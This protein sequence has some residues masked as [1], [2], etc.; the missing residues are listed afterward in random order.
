M[1]QTEFSMSLRLGRYQRIRQ[2][3]IRGSFSICPPFAGNHK[4][5]FTSELLIEYWCSVCLYP[6]QAHWSLLKIDEKNRPQPHYARQGGALES[7]PAV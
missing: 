1:Q 4:S 7:A 3:M 5:K 2:N 6:C